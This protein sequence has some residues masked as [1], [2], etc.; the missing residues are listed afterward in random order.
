[1]NQDGKYYNGLSPVM[2][3]VRCVVLPDGV[4]VVHAETDEK[5]VYWKKEDL[6]QDE[7]HNTAIVLGNKNE[8]GK[9]ELTDKKILKEIGIAHKNVVTSSPR[10]VLMWVG[11]IALFI[12]G[13]WMA[14]P[15][16]TK[17][18]AHRIPYHVERELSAKISLD[19]QFKMCTLA[20]TEKEALNS[21][22]KFLYPK[23]KAEENIAI[24]V[25]VADN[26]MINAFTFP[27]GRIVLMKGLIKETK[28]PEE[29]LGIMSHEIGHVVARDSMSFL[30][31][32][33]FLASFFGFLTGDYNSSFAMSPQIILSTA[34]LTFSRD[35]ER[36]ADSYAAGRLMM[37]KV[38]TSG[39]RSFFS[40]RESDELLSAPELLT[41]H[42]D[43]KN[44]MG[45]IVETY[46]NEELP[47]DILENWLVI[48][49]ICQK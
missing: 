12:C 5:V 15:V 13:F 40:R 35:M 29:L 42:P 23:N 7:I 33:T 41:T 16:M 21:Y 44:R 22:L 26:P 45:W 1:M 19:Q 27:G 17:F 48:K 3:P 32:G 28:S 8:P 9:I 46:P 39:L 24:D 38:S 20:A 4:L 36:A 37:L 10:L 18:I 31:R 30:V 14:I 6:F 25:M 2:T 47:K 34:A 49:N 43:Y 11:M